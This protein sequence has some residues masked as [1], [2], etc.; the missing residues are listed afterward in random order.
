MKGPGT[1]KP[2]RVV[3]ALIE[4]QGLVNKHMHDWV[5]V[6]VSCKRQLLAQVR[7]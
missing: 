1:S 7:E 2:K 6:P 3:P 5:S 4:L